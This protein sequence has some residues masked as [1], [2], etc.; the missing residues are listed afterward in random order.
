[1]AA[2]T[3]HTCATVPEQTGRNK[4]DGHVVHQE[5]KSRDPTF[6]PSWQRLW[7]HLTGSVRVDM[8]AEIELLLLTFCTGIQVS[9]ALMPPRSQTIIALRPTR[10]E[11]HEYWSVIGSVLARRMVY[12]PIRARGGA[13]AETMASLQYRF[14]VQLEGPVTIGVIALLAYASGAQVVLSRAYSCNEISTAMA[15]A[16]WVDLLVDPHLF[17]SNN[18]PRTRRFLFVVSLFLGAVSGAFMYVRMSSA[19][20]ILISGVGK[21]IR[22]EGSG[23][24]A[25]GV[26]LNR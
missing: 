7:Q 20:A 17:S 24:T 16:A 8:Y 2:T 6:G 13:K 23:R 19:F 5:G 14:G 11:T 1:M 15:T 3:Q 21:A 25:S 9:R 22:R 12:R 10:Q 4:N 18:R 26:K